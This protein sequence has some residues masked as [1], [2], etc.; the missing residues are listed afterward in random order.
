MKGLNEGFDP[1]QWWKINASTL[2]HWSVA[3]QKVVLVQPLS[4]AA[5]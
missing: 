5:K 4:A 1:V 3:A 2:P